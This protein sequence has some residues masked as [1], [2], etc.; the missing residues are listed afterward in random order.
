MGNKPYPE[1]FDS[2]FTERLTRH[3]RIGYYI[4]PDELCG[5]ESKGNILVTFVIDQLLVVK[6]LVDDP[7]FNEEL[8]KI[9]DPTEVNVFD[10]N[11]SEVAPGNNVE[12]WT[13]K[14]VDGSHEHADVAH[15]VWNLRHFVPKGM[16]KEMVAPNHVLVPPGRMHE[17][18]WGPPEE[19]GSVTVPSRVGPLIEVVVVDSGFIMSGPAG[20]VVTNVT[21]A[22]SLQQLPGGGP[23]LYDWQPG[24]EAPPGVVDALDQ[25]ADGR[26]DALAGHAN[27]VA[28]VVARGSEHAELTVESLNCSVID[29]DTSIPGF[30]TEAEVARAWWEHRTAPVVNVGYAFATL[31]N[32][33]LAVESD[34]NVVN[35]PPSWALRVV[36][37]AVG[38]NEEHVVVAP[39]GNQDCSVPQYPAAFSVDYDNVAA[40]GS[41]DANGARSV[42]SNYGDWV[43]CCAKGEDVVSTFIGWWDGEAEEG[44]PNPL[45]AATG[46][47]LPHPP[48]HFRGWAS[49][50]GTSF[51]APKVSAAIA[52][53]VAESITPAGPQKTPGQVWQEM[54]ANAPDSGVSMGKLLDTLPPI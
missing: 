39:A 34:P 17:C 12:I 41:V 25:N 7:K 43:N 13:L 3:P 42:F 6:K 50:S 47:P 9:A 54:F 44:E 22:E 48:K 51:A 26:L 38:D 19:H 52:H 24:T 53:G 30:V 31:P 2:G 35:G 32:Q 10:G 8:V 16:Q 27:F 46:V 14:E 28:G 45:A 15:A 4:Y 23:P 49:W 33:A 18:P 29:S 37:E 5:R 20:R 36:M 21:F 11:K 40:V 1:K